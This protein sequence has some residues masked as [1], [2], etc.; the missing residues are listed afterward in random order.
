MKI[1]R[2][3][4]SFFI[5]GLSIILAGC[6]LLPEPSSLIQSPRMASA[7]IQNIESVSVNYLPKGTVP[8]IA[9]SPIRE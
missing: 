2:R 1:N 9:N 4:L 6:G 3:L 7:S 8:V 5:G